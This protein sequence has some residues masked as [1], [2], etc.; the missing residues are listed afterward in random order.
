VCLIAGARRQRKPAGRPRG[1]SFNSRVRD[2]C[3]NISMFR[4]LAQAS[5]VISDCK[6]DDNHRRGHS[7]RGYQAPAVNAAARTHP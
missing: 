2:E 1:L 4:S 5:V 7:A 6:E 3:L